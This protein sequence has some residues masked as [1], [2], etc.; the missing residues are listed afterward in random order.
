MTSGPQAG[1]EIKD[2]VGSKGF[3][4]NKGLLGLQGSQVPEVLQ[5]NKEDPVSN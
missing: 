5:A 3:Q 1:V 4:V 2:L